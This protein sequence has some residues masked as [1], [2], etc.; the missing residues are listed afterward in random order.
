MLWIEEGGT[1]KPMIFSHCFENAPSYNE[2]KPSFELIGLLV[3]IGFSSETNEAEV[4]KFDCSQYHK[5]TTYTN[6]GVDLSVL[7]VL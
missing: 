2:N 1:G 4:T 3:F 6:F 7:K 5:M